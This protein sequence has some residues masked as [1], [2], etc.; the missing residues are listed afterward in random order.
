MVFVFNVRFEFEGSSAARAEKESAGPMKAA[1]CLPQWTGPE[2]IAYDGRA[3]AFERSHRAAQYYRRRVPDQH[4][5]VVLLAVK[6][7]DFAVH[8]SAR[9]QRVSSQQDCL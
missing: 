5:D 1:E 6:F 4:V 2:V 8:S 9:M 7:H 3:L